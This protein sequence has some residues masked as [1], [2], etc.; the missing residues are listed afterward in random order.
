MVSN[1]RNKIHQTWSIDFS[2]ALY[3]GDRPG[4]VP[5]CANNFP[6]EISAL[7]VA[8]V[9]DSG[10]LMVGQFFRRRRDAAEAALT[11]SAGIGIAAVSSIA[12][13]SMR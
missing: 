7:G 8:L 1:S 10:A 5:A 3:S 12:D 4:V 13:A 6:F 9:R 2:Q 11:A